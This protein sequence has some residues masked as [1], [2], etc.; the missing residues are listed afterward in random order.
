MKKK[1]KTTEYRKK[2]IK[3]HRRYLKEHPEELVRLRKIQ[4]PGHAT[5]IEL[6]VKAF[7]NQ[8]FEENNYFYY[9]KY[10]KTKQTFFRPDFQFPNENIIIE[11]DGYYK[12]FTEKGKKKDFQREEALKK[13]GWTVYRFTGRDIEQNFDEVC[14]KICEILDVGKIVA[15]ADEAGSLSLQ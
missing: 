5:K 11:I 4:Y 2:V 3:G 6:K 12:H 9:D 8:F 13:A 1:W 15:G 10:D 7:L 14:S